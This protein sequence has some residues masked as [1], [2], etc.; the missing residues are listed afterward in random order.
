MSKSLSKAIPQKRN[1]VENRNSDQNVHTGKPGRIGRKTFYF[2]LFAVGIFI[3]YLRSMYAVTT[4]SMYTEDGTWMGEIYRNGFWHTLLFAKGSYLVFGNVILLEISSLLNRLFFGNDL[5]NLPYFLTFVSYAFYSALALAPAVCFKKHLSAV[6]RLFVWLF[7]LLMPL[8]DDAP[9]MFGRIS[10]IGYAFLFLCFCFSVWLYDN[11]DYAKQYQIVVV[12]L[13]IFLCPTTNPACYPVV[14]AAFLITFFMEWGKTGEKERNGKNIE[15]VF[16][17]FGMKMWLLLLLLLGLS[18][19]FKMI[20]LRQPVNQPDQSILV[21]ALPE[22]FARSFLYPFLF[23]AWRHLTDTVSILLLILYLTFLIF[24]YFIFK[25]KREKRFYLC[26]IILLIYFVV[27]SLASRPSLTKNLNNHYASSYPDRYFYCATIFTMLVIACILSE[28]LEKDAKKWL[29][30]TSHVILAG[31]CLVYIAGLKQ[32][33]EF[34]SPALKIAT[35]P[36]ESRIEEAFHKNLKFDAGYQVP[37]DFDG[38]SFWIS[39]DQMAS[40]FYHVRQAAPSQMSQ[41][42]ALSQQYLQHPILYQ[43]NLTDVNW[44]N[45]ISRSG[46]VILVPKDSYALKVLSQGK[47]LKAGKETVSIDHTDYDATWIHVTCS[48]SKDLS[49]FAYP[50]KIE[51]IK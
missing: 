7:V 44:Q 39:E 11:I 35:K 38:W 40:S 43:S 14:L 18:V 47:H 17:G 41:L 29:H 5:N 1:P 48:G 45:G 37:I 32:L 21:S 2:G 51:V 4:P 3:I 30:I 9:E 19:L 46:P 27:V 16:S 22:F 20:Y 36:F 8:G 10:N 42:D 49:T 15:A 13:L 31:L 6:A 50:N 23:P 12:D 25:N 28:S 34:N 26:S 24:N 33:F